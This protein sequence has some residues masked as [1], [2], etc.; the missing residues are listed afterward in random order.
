VKAYSIRFRFSRR[1]DDFFSLLDGT[2]VRAR[3]LGNDEC[4]M[5]ITYRLVANFYDS[6]PFTL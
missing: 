4:R 6:Q 3:H 5:P 1:I 2:I